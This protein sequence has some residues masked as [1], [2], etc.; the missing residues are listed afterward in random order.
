MLSTDKMTKIGKYIWKRYECPWCNFKFE[1]MV[2]Y[3][4]GNKKNSYSSIVT[5][6]HCGNI[7]PTWKKEYLK[8]SHGVGRT[9]IHPD[10][11]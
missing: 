4:E 11:R 5:C 2:R 9:H 3:E 8:E 6:Y 7:I 1:K 10:R